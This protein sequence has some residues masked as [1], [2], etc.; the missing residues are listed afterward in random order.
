MVAQGTWKKINAKP[1]LEK[2]THK[3]VLVF[4]QLPQL[5]LTSSNAFLNIFTVM[6]EIFFNGEIDNII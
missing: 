6:F 2:G 5:S 3:A 1:V 4:R